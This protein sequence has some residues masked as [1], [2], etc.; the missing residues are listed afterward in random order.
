MH[1]VKYANILIKYLFQGTQTFFFV[2]RISFYPTG[3]RRHF[4]QNWLQKEEIK[5]SYHDLC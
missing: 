4:P 5:M 1:F 2:W 3:M